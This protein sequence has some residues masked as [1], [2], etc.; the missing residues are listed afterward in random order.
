MTPRNGPVAIACSLEQSQLGVQLERWQNLARRSERAITPTESGLRLTFRALP[1]VEE[2]LHSLVALERSCCSFADWSIH[3]NDN[4][5]VLDISAQGDE[6]IAAVQG[7]FAA[8]RSPH[9]TAATQE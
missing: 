2:E 7:M 8:L 4:Q 9:A 5:L 3:P 1:G 6:A